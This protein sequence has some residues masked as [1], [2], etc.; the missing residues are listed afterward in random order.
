[1]SVLLRERDKRA[2]RSRLTLQVLYR[3]ELGESGRRRAAALA[4]AEQELARIAQFLPGALHAGM[5]LT[6]ISQLTGV[7]RPTLYAIRDRR[8][9]ESR[10]EVV[11]ALLSALGGLGPQSAEQL[12]GL[13]GVEADDVAPL[14][15]ELVTRGLLHQLIGYSSPA[16]PTAFLVL[17]ELGAK[18]LEELLVHVS[19]R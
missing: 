9:P 10:D 2:Q 17:T 15:A 8:P 13:I 4:G 14:V 12:A 19:A 5:T 7:S 16:F 6:E 3:R 18:T 1:M 11:F